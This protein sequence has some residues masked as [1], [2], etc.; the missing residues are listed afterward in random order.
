MSRTDSF[1]NG[2]LKIRNHL[3]VFVL[4]RYAGGAEAVN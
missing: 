3:T 1:P 4:R 2:T